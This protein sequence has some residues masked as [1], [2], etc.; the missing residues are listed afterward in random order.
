LTFEE[1]VRDHDQATG[2]LFASERSI[3]AG[4]SKSM[5]GSNKTGFL[6]GAYNDLGSGRLGE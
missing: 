3:V 1:A 6:P 2:W 5:A 4:D